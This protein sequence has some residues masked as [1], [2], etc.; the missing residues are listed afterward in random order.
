MSVGLKTLW[1]TSI[2]PEKIDGETYVPTALRYTDRIQIGSAAT[3][4]EKDVANREFKLDLGDITRGQSPTTRRQFRCSD[5]KERS[6]YELSQDFIHT[7][8]SKIEHRLPQ[9][10]RT[11]H[12]VPARVV[13]AEPL[14]F[15]IKGRHSSWLTN[16]RENVRR[17]LSRY[18]AV[19]FLPE[20]FA[21]YQYYRYG[22]RVPILVE[23]T[24]H[25]ALIVD[26]GGGTFDT[27]VI[28]STQAGDV[29]LT[30]KHSKPLA[31][32][33]TPHGGFYINRQ[34]AKYMLKR[35]TPDNRKREIERSYE[36]YLR[37]ERGEL[38]AGDLKESTQR[39]IEHMT[40]LESI[41]ER[42][43]L[44]LSGKISNWG[45]T[46]ESYEKVMIPVPIDPFSDCA[47][48][49]EEL[50][51]HQLRRLFIDEVWNRRLMPVVKGVLVRSEDRLGKSN[52]DV[53][54]ISGG[55]AN[56]GWLHRLLEKDFDQQLRY[57][58]PVD[59]RQSFQD[60]VANGLAI[61][62][63]RRHYSDESGDSEFV[64]VTYN[65]IRLMLASDGEDFREYRFKSIDDKIDMNEA[66][67][68]DLVPSAQSLRHFFEDPLQWRVNLQS[69]PKRFLD[70]EFCRPGIEDDEGED[71]AIAYNIEEKRLNTTD[72]RFDRR[73]I[74][75]IV[76]REDGTVAPAFIYK[77]GNPKRG[78][79][80]NIRKCRPFFVD[81][82]T[83]KVG[84]NHASYV[85]FDFG[86]SNSS[87][88][89]LSPVEINVTEKRQRSTS[90][91]GISNAL[92]ILPYP[93]AIAVRRFLALENAERVAD[94]ALAAFEACLALVAYSAAAE[95]LLLDHRFALKFRSFQ[96]RS[97]GP[98]AALLRSGADAIRR[99]G[100]Y[101]QNID[102]IIER[103]DSIDE[104]IKQFNDLKHHKA[105]ISD[106]NWHV[107]VE[108][109]VHMTTDC[110]RDLLFGYCAT[111]DKVVLSDKF[112]G[113][114]VVAHDN[115]PFVA[116][117]RF[118]SEVAVDS[119]IVFLVDQTCKRAISLTP[120]YWWDRVSSDERVCYLLDNFESKDGSVIMKSSHESARIK[121]H[122]VHP[123]LVDA[124]RELHKN[125]RMVQPEVELRLIDVE[126]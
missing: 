96:H 38:R 95:A 74:V 79:E 70:Y 60:V 21:V 56:L 23:K 111:C 94:S 55:S 76:V 103:F 66:N 105:G 108:S 16:Y 126:N 106:Y 45:L 84:K 81:M 72:K 59:I 1:V 121:A 118:E 41:V 104:A 22:C 64:A 50:F 36:Y 15:Q 85:G 31:A 107:H 115:Q 39:F 119:S 62:C 120:F 13:V 49:E 86:T 57:A 90:W 110:M 29:S 32:N 53:T 2:V 48:T 52:I 18:A 122:S 37:C 89:C 97:I 77:S 113:T 14:S 6:A 42:Y 87:V 116:K 65:P 67:P 93:S 25:I 12:R 123:L 46:G 27:C 51:G 101:L 82:T 30:G 71:G 3:G 61:E 44:E 125:G 7:L 91:T 54:L 40:R 19:E 58:T 98:L 99:N 78:I 20:P 24:K 124:I 33:S 43:K 88:C 109:I 47:W 92:S 75:E 73:T 26:F 34:I 112:E 114:F 80:G 102:S 17:I 8:F 117:Y 11:T 9:A 100:R 5:G 10:D 28:E 4:D 69:P 63:A 68:G 83:D 35:M